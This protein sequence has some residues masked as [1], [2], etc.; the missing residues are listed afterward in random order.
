MSFHRKKRHKVPA[1]ENRK[2][3]YRLLIMKA[4]DQE[5]PCKQ[6]RR[7]LR[8]LVKK[9]VFDDATLDLVHLEID[10]KIA[11]SCCWEG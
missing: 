3:A 9:G 8:Y 4:F 1:R 6:V 2:P 5:K 11:K 7:H 10:Q